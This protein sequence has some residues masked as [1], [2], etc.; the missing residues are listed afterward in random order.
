MDAAILMVY[1]SR[2]RPEEMHYAPWVEG[3]WSKVTRA[4]DALEARWMSHLHGPLD[5]GLIATACALAYLDFRHGDRDWR[6]GR[7]SLAAWFEKFAE[8]ESFQATK[9]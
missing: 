7:P 6:T 2:S 1:E 8:R 5:M 3:Q 4:L 9:P